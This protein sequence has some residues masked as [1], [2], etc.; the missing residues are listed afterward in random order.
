MSLFNKSD[1]DPVISKG[2]PAEKLVE[3]DS[4]WARAEMYQ[5]DRYL[6]QAMQV[7]NW[8][9]FAFFGLAIAVIAV[10]GNIY[11]GSKSKFIPVLV[12]VDKL[13]QT[14]AVR[15]LTG[16]DAVTDT[17]RLVY[18]EMIDLIEDLRTVRTDAG[19][20]NADLNKGFARLSGAA[21]TYVRNELKKAPPNVVGATKT[22]VVQVKTAMPIS[23][24]TWQI[25][26]EEDSFDLNGAPIG[27][28]NWK[29]VVSY[30][31][32]P[33]SKEQDIRQ[34]PIGFTVVEMNWT[35]VI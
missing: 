7:K 3:D 35:K 8:R 29:A 23:G 24:R 33:S 6:R 21:A 20:N 12:E 26:W 31:L 14:V 1:V 13:G 27:V 25:E 30:D 34:N 15:A 32:I 16:E 28:E 5:D 2:K 4:V 11:I 10:A 19:A 9:L 18:R 22:V 17:N